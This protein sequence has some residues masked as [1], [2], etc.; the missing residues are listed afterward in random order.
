M[1]PQEGEDRLRHGWRLYLG[2]M[3]AYG[4]LV[5]LLWLGLGRLVG[6]FS[7]T[8]FFD[9]DIE[10]A[11][12]AYAIPI[13]TV[14]GMVGFLAYS[15]ISRS[16]DHL[17]SGLVS[18]FGYLLIALVGAAVSYM[19]ILG[20]VG[21]LGMVLRRTVTHLPDVTLPL[22]LAVASGLAS[23]VGAFLATM[24]YRPTSSLR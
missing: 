13:T 23:A 9:D 7:G 1:A 3:L 12:A 21:V 24:A 10:A 14:A 17:P 20:V 15:L 16:K 2:P 18:W 22:L 5:L 4:S 8:T 19:L 6:F 11:Y